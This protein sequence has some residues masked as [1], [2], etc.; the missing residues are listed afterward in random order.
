MFYIVASQETNCHHSSMKRALLLTGFLV[1]AACS[2]GAS[3]TSSRTPLGGPNAAVTVT[4]FSD[5]ECPACRGAHLGILKPLMEKYGNQIRYDHMHFPLRQ[6]HRY[7]LDAAEASECAAD[8]GK[9]WEYVDILFE[10][11]EDL[12]EE[13]FPA[14]AEQLGLDTDQFNKCMKSHLKRSA[15]LADYKVGRELGVG[16]TPTFFVNGTQVQSGVDTM[17][18]AID[19]EL[20]KLTQRL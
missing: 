6:I 7:S 14:W 8:Q 17:S 18:A 10:R 3:G 13:A 16:G 9:F 2:N 15:V 4:G 20:E 1:L 11:Q 19:A 12:S 5:F